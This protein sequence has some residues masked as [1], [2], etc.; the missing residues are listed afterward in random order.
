M[1]DRNLHPTQRLALLAAVNPQSASTAQ[2]SGWI[3]ASKFDNFL[4]LVAVGALGSGATVDAK[5]QQA[6][7][8]SGTAAKDVAG[9][10][11]TQLTKTGSN[12]NGQCLINLKQDEL[13]FANGYGFIQLSVTPGVAASLIFAA[14]FGFDA[15][16]EPPSQAAS[17]EQT[18]L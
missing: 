16:Y 1:L 3:D 13:D 9:K 17:V 15:R 5:I 6:Q 2:V 14:L 10:A 12:D 8:S 4:A 7:D 18:I 11:V